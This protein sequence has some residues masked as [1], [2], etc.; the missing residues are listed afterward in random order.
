MTTQ[1]GNSGHNYSFCIHLIGNT[2]AKYQLN[3]LRSMRL[4]MELFSWAMRSSSAFS[5]MFTRTYNSCRKIDTEGANVNHK[6]IK[7]SS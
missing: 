2:K 3:L 4:L 6:G 5:H 1:D 7:T